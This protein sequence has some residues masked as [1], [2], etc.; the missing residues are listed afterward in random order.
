MRGGEKD[1][2]IHSKL[3]TYFVPCN[4]TSKS[5]ARFAVSFCNYMK[6]LFSRRNK[7]YAA[8]QTQ[9]LTSFGQTWRNMTLL[10]TSG[11]PATSQNLSLG[12]IRSD[13]TADNLK[14]RLGHNL[15]NPTSANRLRQASSIQRPSLSVPPL[16][17]RLPTF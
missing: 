15:E 14:P 6:I 5:V 11:H 17:L 9:A 13:P 7:L 16:K 1:R 2:E 8:K 3:L 12:N 4:G 10:N